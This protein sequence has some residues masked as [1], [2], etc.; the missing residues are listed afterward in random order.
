MYDEKVY[1][2]VRTNLKKFLGGYITEI[3]SDGGLTK[4]EYFAS[5]AMQSINWQDG[6]V[7]ANSELCLQIA[8]VLIV[9][10]EK[11]MR[12]RLIERIAEYESD[13]ERSREA[14]NAPTTDSSVGEDSN[15]NGVRSE[16]V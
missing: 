10:I 14:A 9:E 13:K 11:R 1:P 8:D 6:D 3:N 5:M 12:K 15:S 16:E 4:L 2:E 7:Q